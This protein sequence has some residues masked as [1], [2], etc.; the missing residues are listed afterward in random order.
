MK[1]LIIIIYLFQLNS[2]LVAQPSDY[3]WYIWDKKYGA[4]APQNPQTLLN[5]DTIQN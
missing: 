5:S 2:I 1:K 4:K 3:Q